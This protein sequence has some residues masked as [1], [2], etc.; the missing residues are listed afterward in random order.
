MGMKELIYGWLQ[1]F[2]MSAIWGMDGDEYGALRG[3][4]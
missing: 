4:I 2:M 3:W 1:I